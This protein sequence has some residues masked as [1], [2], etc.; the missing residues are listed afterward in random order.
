MVTFIGIV[1]QSPD[2]F[3]IAST[4]WDFSAKLTYL[5]SIEAIW[6]GSRFMAHD[7]SCS[8]L[9]LYFDTC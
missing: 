4:P 8:G 5:N 7:L 3:K 9:N 1:D 6:S 2:P